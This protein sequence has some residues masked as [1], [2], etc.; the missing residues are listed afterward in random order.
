MGS[1]AEALTNLEEKRVYE[2]VDQKVNKGEDVLRIISEL[3]EGMINVGKLFSSGEYFI[4]QLIFSGE[5]LK[6][7][8]TK[9]EPLLRKVEA[10][11]SSGKVV[12]GTVKGDIHDIGKNIV[13][14]LLNGSGFDVLDLGV[15]VPAEK[16][17]EAIKQTGA[18]VLGL[19]ALLNFTYPE[20]KSVIEQVEKA[21][22]RD[23]V[24][25]II[26]GAPC[27]EQVREFTG[28]DFCAKDAIAGVNYCKEIY[29]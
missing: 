26:G 7:V 8:M 13:I 15:D 18:K 24:K 28:A 29:R 4:S 14:T 12:I 25:V 3:N 11:Q 21:G 22:L 9:L 10:G 5:I 17:V 1:L 27:N 23:R 16:F 19:S 6:E 20:M 2:L